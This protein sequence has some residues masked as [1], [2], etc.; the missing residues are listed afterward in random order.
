M[1]L[2]INSTESSI[3]GHFDAEDS[4]SN[5]TRENGV[6]DQP[7]YAFAEVA[8][9]KSATNVLE[10]QPQFGRPYHQDDIM[11]FNVTV[12]DPENVAFLIDL[13]TSSTKVS[14]E[15]AEPPQHLGYH[16]ILPNDLR[17]N[18]GKS[19]MQITC[20]TTHRPLGMM[21]IEFVRVICLTTFL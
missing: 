9:L 3:H 21:K 8:T 6:T 2:R 20:A 15:N 14:P 1:N 11:I 12:G 7:V 18:D 19:E 5:D 10:P 13:Y 17:R 16:Y 4:V